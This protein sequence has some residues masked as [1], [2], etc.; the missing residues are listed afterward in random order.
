MR[1]LTF[2]VSVCCLVGQVKIPN[3][4]H[5]QSRE[6]LN[7]RPLIDLQIHNGPCLVLNG[8]HQYGNEPQTQ[9]AHGEEV[10]MIANR[11]AM[12]RGGVFLSPRPHRK[13]NAA[14]HDA[15]ACVLDTASLHSSLSSPFSLSSPPS[16]E[17]AVDAR[18]DRPK[19][20]A[21]QT[22]CQ[23]ENNGEEGEGREGR[24]CVVT[25]RVQRPS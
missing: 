22:H 6:M 14:S 25:P 15:P 9:A 4:E 24:E 7:R 8:S 21:G 12:P 10:A 19:L 13:F 23:A 3:R 5:E 11:K 17:P 20:N 1:I 16:G 2:S 18:K